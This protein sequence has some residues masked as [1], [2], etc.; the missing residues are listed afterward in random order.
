M[1]SIEETDYVAVEAEGKWR[2]VRTLF[3]NT[4]H[5]AAIERK[6][7]VYKE[8]AEAHKCLHIYFGVKQSFYSHDMAL[9]N[10]DTVLF[11]SE[12]FLLTLE[13]DFLEA[14]AIPVGLFGPQVRH[15]FTINE[16]MDLSQGIQDASIFAL[17][18]ENAEL[19]IDARL[20]TCVLSGP[21]IIDLHY[22]N[23]KEAR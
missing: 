3:V 20:S 5:R 14:P 10:P 21:Q 23:E 18:Y 4:R 15:L 17:A 13:H 9:E 16:Q 19:K 12:R 22:C 2:G 6:P 8:L 11:L 7:E 1:T